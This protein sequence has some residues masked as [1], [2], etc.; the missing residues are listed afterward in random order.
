MNTLDSP[1]VSPLSSH[2]SLGVVVAILSVDIKFLAPKEKAKN[3][4]H[5]R[6]CTLPWPGV[7]QSL[8]PEPRHTL[9][10]QFISVPTRLGLHPLAPPEP[11]PIALVMFT[12]HAESP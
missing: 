8:D 1:D 4:S 5:F 7:P 11:L 3:S 12:Q 9:A 6:S 2:Y 10:S